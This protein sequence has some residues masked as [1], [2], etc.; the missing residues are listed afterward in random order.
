[1]GRRKIEPLSA[2]NKALIEENKKLKEVIKELEN[3]I[4]GGKKN[5]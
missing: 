1:M 3:K 4:S 5:E 2:V